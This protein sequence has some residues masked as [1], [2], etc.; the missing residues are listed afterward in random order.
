MNA[1]GWQIG[2]VLFGVAILIIA[3]YIAKTLNTATKT[4]DRVNKIIDYN[5]KNLNQI[6][7]NAADITNDVRSILDVVEKVTGFFKVLRI[8][9]K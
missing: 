6:I 1:I 3:I 7:D 2:A 5:E 8:F 9:K 4:I